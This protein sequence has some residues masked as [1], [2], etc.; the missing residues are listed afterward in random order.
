M[1]CP[2][3][4]P[5]RFTE[6]TRIGRGVHGT[7][8]KV[9]DTQC[10]FK[11]NQE[12]SYFAIKRIDY[13]PSDLTDEDSETFREIQA[14]KAVRNSKYVIHLIEIYQ[15]KTYI[16][17]LFD[18]MDTD[19]SQYMNSISGPVDGSLIE[20]YSYQLVLALKHCH[21]Q[22]VIHRDVKPQ[23]ILIDKYGHLKLCDFSISMVRSIGDYNRYVCTLWYRAPEL[24]LL[25]QEEYGFEIDIWSLGCVMMQMV[26][27]TPLFIIGCEDEHLST[28]FNIRGSPINLK[29]V[30][31]LGSFRTVMS[32]DYMNLIKKTLRYDPAKRITSEQAE[33]HTCFDKLNKKLY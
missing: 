14:L 7:V 30:K 11:D 29:P 8:Y 18:C 32:D 2:Q 19:L 3:Y 6:K 9:K 33:S 17:L 23:N 5:E 21:K 10:K 12:D 31:E 27:K 20:S 28:I 22:N 1:N 13:E 24:F 4:D 26:C 25:D 16:W 15:S